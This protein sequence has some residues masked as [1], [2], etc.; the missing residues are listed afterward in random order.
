VGG[1]VSVT[2]PVQVAPDPAAVRWP[3]SWHVYPGANLPKDIASLQALPDELPGEGKSIKAVRVA[4]EN[5][6]IDFEKV[7][8]IMRERN[9]GVVLAVVESDVEQTVRVGASADWWMAWYVNGN[10]VYDTLNVGNGAGYAIT[11]HTFDMP[12]KQ[13][14]N[15]VAV[16]VLSGSQGWKVLV[17][18]PVSLA[19][20][21]GT[22]TDRVQL[23][24]SRNGSEVIDR[25]IVEPYLRLPIRAVEGEV[26]LTSQAWDATDADITLG[27]AS[28]TNEFAKQPD[29]S[30]WWKGPTDLSARVWLRADGDAMHVI[31]AVRDQMHT[32][33]DR[34]SIT[35]DQ[36]Q[37]V[38][39]TGATAQ[40][41]G[42]ASWYFAKLPGTR[43]TNMGKVSVDISDVDE[44]G[45]VKQ[46]A[47]LKEHL[48]AWP[49]VK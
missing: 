7:G 33:E 21:L 15:I 16:Q 10:R 23:A 5:F 20:K 30:R 13:G 36:G 48:F 19:R 39:L 17:G 34:V 2:V 49:M 11:D 27:E 35:L 8:G 41:A 6:R 18:D 25:Q 14:R 3:A 12:L 40:R 38:V 32:D 45:Y 1:R 24:L 22:S 4:P 28:V 31:V 43:S 29:A 9:P 26:E 47:A 37:P 42:E 44:P 46:T